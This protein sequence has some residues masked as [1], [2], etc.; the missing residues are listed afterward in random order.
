MTLD[1]TGGARQPL[2]YTHP[3][4]AACG[5]S[6]GDSLRVGGDGGGDGSAAARD[7]GVMRW[8]GRERPPRRGQWFP[9]LLKAQVPLRSRGGAPAEGGSP[10]PHSP[11]EDSGGDPSPCD[12]DTHSW[13]VAKNDC[14]GSLWSLA[15]RQGYR[16]SRTHPL[17]P[18]RT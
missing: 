12:G 1:D 7:R 17:E 15:V 16:L 4:R 2:G 13:P 5:D 3:C 6:S 18:T 10:S 11:R 9:R 14:D 8:T